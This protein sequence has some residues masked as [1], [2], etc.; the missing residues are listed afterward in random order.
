ME[1]D[2]I[3]TNISFNPFRIESLIDDHTA[4]SLYRGI[5][6][7]LELIKCGETHKLSFEFLY[8]TCYRL[9]INNYGGMLYCGVL[10]FIVEMLEK[11]RKDETLDEIVNFWKTF[12]ITMD[13]LHD[14][15]MYLEKNFIISNTKVPIKTAGMS[16]FLKYYLLSS[17]RIVNVINNVLEQLN[18]IRKS[19]KLDI[20]FSKE[21]RFIVE[22]IL[23]L[24]SIEVN[25]KSLPEDIVDTI[26]FNEVCCQS[27]IIE[28]DELI[29]LKSKIPLINRAYDN[30]ILIFTYKFNHK[31][32][33]FNWRD[34]A[35]FNQFFMPYFLAKSREYHEKEFE[36]SHS[37]DKDS[38]SQIRNY[39]SK[40]EQ[41]YM[42]EKMIVENCLVFQVWE[43]LIKEMDK[44][45][46]HPFFERFSSINLFE[47]FLIGAKNDLQQLF[48]ILSRV[49]ECLEQLKNSLKQFFSIR[50]D[51]IF[52]VDEVFINDG[53]KKFIDEVHLFKCRS[54]FIFIEC[55][56]NNSMFNQVLSVSFEDFFLNRNATTTINLIVNGFD[57]VLRSLYNDNKIDENNKHLDTLFWLFKYVSNKSLFEIKYRT[58]LCKRLMEFDVNKRNIEH[59]IIIKLR[60]ECGHGY[61]LK[62]EGILADMIQSEILNMEFQ[63]I[64]NEISVL[65]NT[66]IN[67]KVITPNFW[68][69]HPYINFSF[70]NNL[71][72]K[73]DNFTQFF[74]SKYERRKLQWHLGEGSAIINV[75]LKSRFNKSF[76]IECSTIQMFILDIFNTFDFISF[77]EMQ[78]IIGC[79]DINLLKHNLLCLVFEN[80]PLLNIIP[81]TRWKEI[82]INNKNLNE[83]KGIIGVTELNICPKEHFPTNTN[84]LIASVSL[85]DIICINNDANV[86]DNSI[87]KYNYDSLDLNYEI[88]QNFDSEG[89]SI[90]DKGY[91]IDSIIVRNL[92]KNKTLHIDDITRRVIN[93]NDVLLHGSTELIVERLEMLCQKEFVSKD[94]FSQNLYSYVP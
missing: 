53:F 77:E 80:E 19:K 85:T 59:N 26:R 55:F 62:L 9:T 69:T 94:L 11:E 67:Y 73:L 65:S 84:S 30:K 74:Y 31:A 36:I 27:T 48:R 18:Y 14:V 3:P 66:I 29:S 58:L 17:N 40:C 35:I 63:Q 2:L 45:W 89:S 44:V 20:N 52:P 12:E 86:K 8:R 57:I 70:L 13:T 16:I 37:L 78:K 43:E 60:G 50:L 68:I 93:H 83:N 64:N 28:D 61:T 32:P 15:L 34:F 76:T 47:F 88:K 33:E 21:I 91:I 22:Q 90:R 4:V 46:I 92:K 42:F 1:M 5:Y 82:T 10:D 23:S 41:N 49:P 56:K 71:N 38:I 75:N 87:I 7:C 81:I 24:P 25:I 6:E 79:S 51:K 54:E 39:L 72:C